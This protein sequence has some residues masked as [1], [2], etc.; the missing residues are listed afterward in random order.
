MATKYTKEQLLNKKIIDYTFVISFFFIFSFFIIFAIKP[1]LVTAFKLQ[2][3]L[4]ELEQIDSNYNQAI[5]TII[6]IQSSLEKDRDNL[7]LLDEALPGQP[8]INKVIAD[9]QKAASQSGLRVNKLI[10]TEV[11]V[12]YHG[13]E[14]SIKNF[15]ITFDSKS[16]FNEVQQFIS[17][18]LAQRRLKLLEKVNLVKS[19]TVSSESAGLSVTFEIKSYFL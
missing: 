9:V 13:T 6:K 11:P 12:T 15:T 19:Q 4:E 14:K 2:K 17:G 18:F 1:N 3:E 5:E 16:D 8:Q 10:V 7:P